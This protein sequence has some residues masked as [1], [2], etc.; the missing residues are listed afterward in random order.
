MTEFVVGGNGV[1]SWSSPVPPN[2]VILYYN[3]IISTA[4]SGQL[5]TRVEELDVLSID[6]SNYGEINMDYNVTV[7]E[8]T[9]S[10]INQCPVLIETDE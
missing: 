10:C 4:D 3:V 5:V 8:G 2:G 1:L 6:V 9:A 7:R